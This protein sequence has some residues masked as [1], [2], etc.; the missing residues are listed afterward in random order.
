MPRKCYKKRLKVPWPVWDCI[1]GRGALCSYQST[2]EKHERDRDVLQVH[3]SP[4]TTGIRQVLEP[5]VGRAIEADDSGF[6]EFS[7]RHH[8]G[9]TADNLL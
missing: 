4:L 7:G 6:Y 2:P 5:D 3:R 1:E 8:G 9:P